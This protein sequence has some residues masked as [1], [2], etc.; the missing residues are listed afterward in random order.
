MPVVPLLDSKTKHNMKMNTIDG[1]FAVASDNL[2]NPYLGL[3]A[4]SLGATTS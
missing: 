1:T 3:F 4:L 2:T